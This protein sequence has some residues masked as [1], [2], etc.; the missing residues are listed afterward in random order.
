MNTALALLILTSTLTNNATTSLDLISVTYRI[1]KFQDSVSLDFNLNGAGQA[2]ARIRVCDNSFGCREDM[3]STIHQSQNITFNQT[4][5]NKVNILN[6][7]KNNESK[8][9]NVLYTN[10]LGASRNLNFTITS[11]FPKSYS[12]V[13]T[14][15]SKVIR[16]TSHIN[17]SATNVVS[18]VSN[19]LDFRSF[20]NK[21]NQS[22]I[23]N[24]KD[25]LVSNGGVYLNLG[26]FVQLLN[27]LENSELTKVSSYYHLDF[28]SRTYEDKILLVLDNFFVNTTTKEMTKLQTFNTIKTENIILSSNYNKALT[29]NLI[30]NFRNVGSHGS[31]IRV[32]TPFNVVRDIFGNCDQAILCINKH[33]VRTINYSRTMLIR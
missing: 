14:T 21:P 10:N 11:A 6:F 26:G 8:R 13:S 27:G 32:T 24:F 9:I 3:P 15:L 7:T 1:T 4:G 28:I 5:L 20:Y 19:S 29:N 18:T 25:Y 22:M 30:F 16:E 12:I 2:S 23:I 31:N 17:V 33:P